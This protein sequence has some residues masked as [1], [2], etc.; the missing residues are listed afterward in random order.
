[1]RVAVT[2]NAPSGQTVAR[3]L[4]DFSGHQLVHPEQADVQI[5]DIVM[6]K[7]SDLGHVPT[8]VM[9]LLGHDPALLL[10]TRRILAGRN[11][12]A[13]IWTASKYHDP[14]RYN[15]HSVAE[16]VLRCLRPGEG[17]VSESRRPLPLDLFRRIRP[18]VPFSLSVEDCE[19]DFDSDR[20]I[21]V[22]FAGSVEYPPTCGPRPEIG[23]VLTRHRED[24]C[25][26]LRD[27]KGLNV[28][29]LTGRDRVQTLQ[30][31]GIRIRLV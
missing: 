19:P 9:D 27:L 13:A 11:P 23:P 10:R 30:N 24:C 12:P 7:R 5:V 4:R 2:S 26:V 31:S 16:H 18:L 21:D 3:I 15:G 25:R 29:C 8:V 6:L 22:F 28:V 14:E 20:P 1:V 17:I